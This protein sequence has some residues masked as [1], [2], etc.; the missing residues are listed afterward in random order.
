[1][2]WVILDMEAVLLKIP[3]YML[4]TQ[5]FQCQHFV[6]YLLR[7]ICLVHSEFFCTHLIEP[8]GVCRVALLKSRISWDV[9]LRWRLNRCRH[10]EGN[11]IIWSIGYYSPKTWC[12]VPE[13]LN[14][15]LCD[16]ALLMKLSESTEC[17]IH[18][19]PVFW[20]VVLFLYMILPNG[21][22]HFRGDFMSF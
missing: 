22:P 9:L 17:R 21:W 6:F 15:P 3:P 11:V 4:W 13:D 1:M 5:P 7:P 20:A 19:W 10:V 14:F 2:I 12:Y 18:H 16:F 8:F